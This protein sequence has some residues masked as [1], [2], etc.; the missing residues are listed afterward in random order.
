MIWHDEAGYHGFT[1]PPTRFDHALVGA[2]HRILSKHD[3]GGGGIQE[4]LYD[5]TDAW[6]GEQADALKELAQLQRNIEHIKEIVAMQQ[7][8]AQVSGVTERVKVTDLV[9]YALRMN[10]GGLAQQQVKLVREYQPHLPEITVEKHKVLQILVNLIRNAKHACVDSGR[11]DK[12][13]TL[14][15]TNGNDRVR[16]AVSDNGVG[17]AS[18]N[19]TRIFSHGFTTKKNGHG[20]GLHSGALAA[21]EIGGAL[22]AHSAGPGTG[23]TFTLELPLTPP[24]GRREGSEGKEIFGAGQNISLALENQPRAFAAPAESSG[25][26]T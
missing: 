4:R 8:Y 9:D 15:V 14:C 25:G 17:I 5:Y 24:S 20:F 18:E 2:G 3:P 19:L 26:K 7:G 1:K 12:L 13:L 6:S 23:A 16:I 21:K 10:Q 22:H 11:H